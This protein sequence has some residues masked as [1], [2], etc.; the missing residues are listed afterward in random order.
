MAKETWVKVGQSRTSFFEDWRAPQDIVGFLRSVDTQKRK[1]KFG[2]QT[3]GVIMKL[4]GTPIQIKGS[5]ESPLGQFLKNEKVGNKI[6]IYYKGG[7]TEDGRELPK[8]IKDYKAFKKW[9]NKERFFKDMEFFSLK[10]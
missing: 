3:V 7:S 8:G 10:K 6:R 4:D 5:E 2:P 1:G 9:K